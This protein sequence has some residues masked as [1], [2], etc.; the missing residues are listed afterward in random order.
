MLERNHLISTTNE[1]IDINIATLDGEKA[2]LRKL[3]AD[4]QNVERF[5]LARLTEYV[6]SFQKLSFEAVRMGL[7]ASFE[8][9][10]M[11]ESTRI[12]RLVQRAGMSANV[13]YN[14]AED[15]EAKK[16]VRS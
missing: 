16:V 5:F 4:V 10:N 9:G 8:P 6:A 12:A 2:F 1:N 15:E 11:L 7:I 14:I 3:R 13:R